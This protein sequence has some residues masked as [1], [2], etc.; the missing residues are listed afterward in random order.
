MENTLINIL[1]S[2]C[3][4]QLYGMGGA[5][6]RRVLEVYA[7]YLK[8]TICPTGDTQELQSKYQ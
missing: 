1:F 2:Y 7:D 5:S 4:T 8:M 6:K 3:K